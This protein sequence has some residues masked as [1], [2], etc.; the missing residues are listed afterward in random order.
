MKFCLSLSLLS[1]ETLSVTDVPAYEFGAGQRWALKVT[2][3][4]RTWYPGFPCSKNISINLGLPHS[5]VFQVWCQS[6]RHGWEGA[7][8]SL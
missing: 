4:L 1:I 7:G 2:E 8:R 5:A 3:V 6:E